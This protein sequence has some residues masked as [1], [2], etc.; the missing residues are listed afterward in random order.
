M[1]VRTKR[2]V[3]AWARALGLTVLIFITAGALVLAGL[4]NAGVL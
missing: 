4:K 1:N 3:K 2:E